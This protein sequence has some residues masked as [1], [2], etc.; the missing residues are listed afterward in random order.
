M[1]I[2]TFSAAASLY[3]TSEHYYFRQMHARSNSV[4]PVF[5]WDPPQITVTYHP[6]V[7]TITGQNFTPDANVLLRI[8]GCDL[9]E[10]TVPAHTTP[11]SELCSDPLHCIYSFGGSFT[12]AVVCFCGNRAVVSASDA[13]G[14][15][16]F[17]N[18]D[19]LCR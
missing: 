16:A 15:T 8:S 7:L 11:S 3:G 12:S 14:T 5:P 1:T 4:I 17:G 6:S 9:N 13:A 19:A 18:I 10:F 2:P